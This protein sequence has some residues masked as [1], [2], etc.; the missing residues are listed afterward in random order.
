MATKRAYLEYVSDVNQQPY[1]GTPG[2]YISYTTD[3][4][5]VYDEENSFDSDGVP[6]IN[7]RFFIWW[8]PVDDKNSPVFVK[9]RVQNE[10]FNSQSAWSVPTMLVLPVRYSIYKRRVSST[11]NTWTLI[12]TTYN[13]RV[14]GYQ[15]NWEGR[16]QY[17]VGI[18]HRFGKPQASEGNAWSGDFPTD[19]SNRYILF[20]TNPN[21]SMFDTRRIIA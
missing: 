9:Y 16:V 1:E 21:D 8:P 3:K 7:K 12:E 14:G 6:Q 20:M 10:S 4:V 15:E 5:I 17:A 13:N 18:H 19:V 2:T 11:P